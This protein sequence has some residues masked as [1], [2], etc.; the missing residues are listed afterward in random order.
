MT[1]NNY[2]DLDYSIWTKRWDFTSLWEVRKKWTCYEIFCECKCWHKQRVRR[3]ELVKK[4]RCCFKCASAKKINKTHWLSWT[5]IYKIW[6]AMQQRLKNPNNSNYK[7]YWWRWIICERNSFEEFYKDMSESYYEHIKNY[8][9]NKW[10]T[11][12]RIDNNKNYSKDNCKWI[13]IAEQNANKQHCRKN[14]YWIS[15]KDFAKKY[16][17]SIQNIVTRFKRC[18]HDFN[19]L[20]EYMENRNKRKA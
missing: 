4:T 6:T 3:Q 5:A 8:W 17:C 12:E 19:K 18:N 11:I 16:W 7:N 1:K 15:M 9:A 10:T 14:R 2:W 20:V 13:T